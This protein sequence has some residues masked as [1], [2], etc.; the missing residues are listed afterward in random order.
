MDRRQKKVVR[1]NVKKTLEH[2]TSCGEFL[3]GDLFELSQIP[4]VQ[5]R[6][7]LDQQHSSLIRDVE[8]SIKMLKQ[9]L[10]KHKAS[11]KTYREFF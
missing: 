7:D 1:S 4:L 6:V 8:T 9:A 10:V 11:V 2:L 5:I 3:D